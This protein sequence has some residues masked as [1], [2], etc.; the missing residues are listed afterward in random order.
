V[1]D[2]CHPHPAGGGETG[3]VTEGQKD[4]S[5]ETSSL[6][7]PIIQST[8]HVKAP[9][10]N[11]SFSQFQHP[12]GNHFGLGEKRVTDKKRGTM[13]ANLLGSLGCR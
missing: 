13:T 11:V 8:Q 10:L 9:Y 6:P 2:V 3:V 7:H 5:S 12:E 1:T 4:L